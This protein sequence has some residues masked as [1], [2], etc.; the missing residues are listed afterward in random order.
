MAKKKTT[1]T[2]PE[3]KVRKIINLRSLAKLP[4]KSKVVAK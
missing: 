3:K 2:A 1:K 4:N